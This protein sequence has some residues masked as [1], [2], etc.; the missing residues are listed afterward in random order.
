MIQVNIRTSGMFGTRVFN[1][2]LPEDWSEVPDKLRLPCLKE[3]YYQDRDTAIAQNLIRLLRLPRKLY[4]HFSIGVIYDLRQQIEWM[5][6]LERA[7][8]P[9]TEF[10]HNK[11][12]FYFPK[13]ILE[14]VTALEYAIADDLFQEYM[15][16][17]DRQHLIELAA[18][19]CRP[20]NDDKDEVQTTG[21]PR[22]P[23]IGRGQLKSL[24]RHFDD[25][26]EYLLLC[27]LM[28]FIGC[29]KK[30]HEM[31]AG[32]IFPKPQDE[33]SDEQEISRSEQ[34]EKHKWESGYLFGW[35]SVFMDVAQNGVFGSLEQVHKT[36]FHTICMYLVQQ[37]KYQ[38]MREIEQRKQ[39]LRAKNR[40]N[41]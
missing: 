26:P 27:I 22:T 13:P 4:R 15:N 41:R 29:R 36:P 24:A 8:P 18:L 37:K 30:I 6:F 32:W 28:F 5:R 34:N 39:E 35:H 25:L 1:R 40:R 17:G 2:Q 9:I 16:Q 20:G 10:S 12:K 23:L 33:T 31:Y 14:N 7:T 38:E 3:L 21:D 11:V 19:L